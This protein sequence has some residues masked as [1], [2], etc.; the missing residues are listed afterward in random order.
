MVVVRGTISMI[1][2]GRYLER[3]QIHHMMD[4]DH[5]GRVMGQPQ[6]LS[7]EKVSRKQRCLRNSSQTW[8]NENQLEKVFSKQRCLRG[9]SQWGVVEGQLQKRRCPGSKGAYV[10]PL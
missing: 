10:T 3:N 7:K 8:R 5:G 1:P 2:C 9:S 6:K 4:S